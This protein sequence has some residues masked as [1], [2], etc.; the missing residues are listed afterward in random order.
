MMLADLG[1]E[2]IL[3]EPPEGS[4]SRAVGPFVED[5]KVTLRRLCGFGHTTVAR[6]VSR[7]I[8]IPRKDSRV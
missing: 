3:I 5:E 4:R 8:W 7:L 1:A 6:E 2:V